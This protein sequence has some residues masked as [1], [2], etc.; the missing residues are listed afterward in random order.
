MPGPVIL[1]GAGPG[2][3]SDIENTPR[4]A[5]KKLGYVVWFTA[6]PVPRVH[7]FNM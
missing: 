4:S 5:P 7:A 6:I 3:I 2:L 1:F